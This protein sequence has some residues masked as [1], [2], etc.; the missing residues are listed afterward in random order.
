M[1]Y[2]LTSVATILFAAIQAMFHVEI[3]HDKA[4]TPKVK[5]RWSLIWLAIFIPLTLVFVPWPASLP[6]LLGMRV[7]FSLSFRHAL[8][9]MMGWEPGYI[10][11]TALYDRSLRYVF[12]KHAVN[13]ANWIETTGIVACMVATFILLP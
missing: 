12:G 8:A 10:G 2:V 9:Y 4:M 1:I 5:L 6:M 11:T 13:A 7:L 3:I